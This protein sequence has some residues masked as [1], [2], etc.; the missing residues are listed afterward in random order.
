MRPVLLLKID[1]CACSGPNAFSKLTLASANDKVSSGRWQLK[2]LHSQMN[3]EIGTSS[4]VKSRPLN[5]NGSR[6]HNMIDT[7]DE[8]RD[9]DLMLARH[10]ERSLSIDDQI[11]GCRNELLQHERCGISKY[12]EVQSRHH[13]TNGAL[14]ALND[15][16]LDGPELQHSVAY[17]PRE[18]PKS[19][20]SRWTKPL[21][22]EPSV[23]DDL[24]VFKP[25]TFETTSGAHDHANIESPDSA[26]TESRKEE[27]QR[28]KL[29]LK[30][31]SQPLE[32]LGGNARSDRFVT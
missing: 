27:R 5:V 21:D 14:S 26:G 13:H 30:P 10:A 3:F 18:Q 11:Q 32:K 9:S 7:V 19:N 28:P 16:K 2:K 31:R 17:E 6:T 8:K 25:S 15:A 22:S 1:Q 20:F 23:A 24:Q 12:S 4:D 29:N